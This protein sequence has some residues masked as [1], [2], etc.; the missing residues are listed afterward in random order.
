MKCYPTSEIETLIKNLQLEIKRITNYS[1]EKSEKEKEN[2]IKKF[3]EMT[4][5]N[6]K[7]LEIERERRMELEYEIKILRQSKLSSLNHNQPNFN[8][9]LNLSSSLEL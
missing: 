7:S 2:W 6:S 3:E 1:S 9:T 8:N 4:E 5:K